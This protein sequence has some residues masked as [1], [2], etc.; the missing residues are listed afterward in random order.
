MFFFGDFRNLYVMDNVITYKQ[1]LEQCPFKINLTKL[2]LL[3]IRSEAFSKI[4]FFLGLWGLQ[5][6]YG[7]QRLEAEEDLHLWI[8]P[9]SLPGLVDRVWVYT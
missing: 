3:S 8:L 4:F 5:F 9:I 1:Q 2:V 6:G 7:R